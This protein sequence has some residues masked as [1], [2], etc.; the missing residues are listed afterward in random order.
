LLIAKLKQSKSLTVQVG[1]VSNQATSASAAHL[2][3]TK[4]KKPLIVLGSGLFSAWFETKQIDRQA[5]TRKSLTV[6][7]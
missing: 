6:V 2:F 3:Q 7:R 1:V 4:Q 5:Q